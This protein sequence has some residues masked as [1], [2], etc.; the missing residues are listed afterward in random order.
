MPFWEPVPCRK[1]FLEFDLSMA[2]ICEVLAGFTRAQV[3]QL[4][5][6]PK[7][8]DDLVNRCTSF[9]AGEP[10]P[11]SENRHG[12]GVPAYH[13]RRVTPD[14]WAMYSVLAER[15][16]SQTIEADCDQLVIAW[17]SFFKIANP[18]TRVA[19]AASQ[20]RVKRSRAGGVVGYGMAHAYLR[21]DGEPYDP[22]VLAG[23]RRPRDPNFY[24]SGESAAVEL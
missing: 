16:P 8:R 23:M 9:L 13:Y 22:S 24:G 5:R 6:S 1:M 21:L 18:K 20:P 2:E 3:L 17:A 15:F 14:T 12:E 10:L 4:E 19:I 11:G 7:L